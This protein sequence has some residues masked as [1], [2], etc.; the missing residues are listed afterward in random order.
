MEQS[1]SAILVR[2]KKKLLDHSEE[3]DNECDR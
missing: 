2:A 3:F 1:A